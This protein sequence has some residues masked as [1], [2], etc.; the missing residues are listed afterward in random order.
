MSVRDLTRWGVRLRSV[1]G[2]GRR[3]EQAVQEGRVLGRTSEGRPV[4]WASP[5]PERAGHSVIL[6]ASGA[7]KTVMCANVLAG[8][9]VEGG[10][11]GDGRLTLLLVDMKGD[12]AEAVT[13][14]IAAF[15]P[16]R[17]ADL[18]VLDPFDPAG[19]FAFNLNWSPLGETPVDI[20]ALQLAGLVGAVSTATGAQAHL[21]LGARQLDVL[22]NVLLAA[23][24][25]P[26]AQAN[27]L[28]AYDALTEKNGP[29]LLA[30]LTTS[31]RAKSFLLGAKLS[32]ELRVS[33]ASRLRSAFAASAHLE[34]LISAPGCVEWGELLAPGNIVII[35]L[36]RPTGGL[37]ALQRFYGNLL[38]R[39]AVDHLLERRS[40]WKGHHVRIAVDEAQVVAPVLSEVA[41][42][43]LTT[44]RSRGLSLA[45][46]SQGTTLLKDASDT[47]LRV[48]MT[49]CPTRLIGRLSA[50]DAELLSRELAPK[51]GVDETL[52]ALRTDFVSEVTNLP[53]RHFIQLTP[54]LAERF[55]SEDV[56]LEAWHAAAETHQGAIQA[57]R[58]AFA[59]LSDEPRVRLS[60]AAGDAEAPRP[61][62]RVA[63][64]GPQIVDAPDAPGP[65]D[66]LDVA[67]SEGDDAVPPPRSRWG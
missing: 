65:P 67:T 1:L 40:P 57:A 11:G 18:R 63:E 58:L 29:K 24:S 60:T 48:L 61:R 46:I 32:D 56:D 17:L 62:R 50:P 19:G 9:V 2:R 52:S 12:L 51:R 39:L 59:L 30:R 45:T 21:G 15:A 14:A 34:R 43:I 35:D 13:Q 53:D 8:E 42:T 22:Q 16:E 54:G 26:H 4:I 33:T 20:R 23:L 36:G 44:G 27:V 41:E 31:E 49:N 38:V 25:C 55:V 28:W 5:R 7:G 37:V 3:G 10:V 64:A 47:L 6:A 66:D